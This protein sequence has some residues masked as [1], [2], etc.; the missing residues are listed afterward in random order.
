MLLDTREGHG[1]CQDC[2]AA[3]ELELVYL[4]RR[5]LQL[6]GHILHELSDAQDAVRQ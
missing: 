2:F 4:V 3:Q 5:Q 1:A 6:L